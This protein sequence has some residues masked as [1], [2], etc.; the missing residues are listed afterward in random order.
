MFQ[1]LPISIEGADPP[2]GLYDSKCSHHL[3]Y[4][5]R[6]RLFRH[7]SMQRHCQNSHCHYSVTSIL[8]LYKFMEI[9]YGIPHLIKSLL[10][11]SVRNHSLK[12]LTSLVFLY[13][14]PFSIEQ[15]FLKQLF[16][17]SRLTSLHPYILHLT[18]RFTS[19]AS[20]AKH[21][22]WRNF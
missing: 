12:I 11:N 3:S 7:S 14:H 2:S 17:K 16:W 5:K 13:L 21:H 18:S 6:S 4:I 20:G 1:F 15:N 9:N 22:K 8:V 19:A 10:K